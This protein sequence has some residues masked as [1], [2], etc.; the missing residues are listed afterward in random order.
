MNA[1]KSRRLSRFR[2]DILL[3]SL[4]LV[5]SLTILLAVSL[6]RKEG[7]RV[8]VLLDGELLAEY[9]LF[10]EG[11]YELNGGTNVLVINGGEAYLTYADCP[12]RTCINTGKIRFVGESI[13]CLPNKLAIT[14][15]GEGDG[16]DLVS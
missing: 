13:I 7:A 14:V 5:L 1:E 6:T 9:S 4:L 15:K 10:E 12:D 8:E 3:I 16:V 2:Y 11:E